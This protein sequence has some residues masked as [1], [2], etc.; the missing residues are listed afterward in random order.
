MVPKE[1]LDTAAKLV[2]LMKRVS[3]VPVA[4]IGISVPSV[5][6]KRILIGSKTLKL[7]VGSPSKSFT[8]TL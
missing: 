1:A 8:S 2:K 4:E 5:A 6:T 3:P 7:I